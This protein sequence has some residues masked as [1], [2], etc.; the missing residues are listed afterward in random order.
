VI[1]CPFGTIFF[2]AG[3][4][5]AAKCDLCAGEPAC[6]RACPTGAI[7]AVAGDAPAWIDDF[8]RRVDAAW[9][10]AAAGGPR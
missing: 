7:A 8:G 9:R 4:G 1:A 10:R 2:D 6:A 3:T 5:T